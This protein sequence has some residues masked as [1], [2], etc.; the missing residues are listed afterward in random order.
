MEHLRKKKKKQSKRPNA[1]KIS[2]QR[3]A[4][5]ALT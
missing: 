1:R 2:C 3:T 5:K 4:Q